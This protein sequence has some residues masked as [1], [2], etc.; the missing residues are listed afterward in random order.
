MMKRLEKVKNINLLSYSNINTFN[1]NGII[2][3][4]YAYYRNIEN[5]GLL[6]KESEYINNKGKEFKNLFRVYN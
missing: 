4:S 1:L 5:M 3:M 2:N 6:N